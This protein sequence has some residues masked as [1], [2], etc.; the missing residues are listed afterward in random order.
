M[1][2]LAQRGFMVPTPSSKAAADALQ[3]L[4]DNQP[5][6]RY[7][8]TY[9]FEKQFDDAHEAIRL[10]YGDLFKNKESLILA[11]REL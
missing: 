5:V 11:I 8:P 1:L 6:Q 2:T 7:L 4:I 10:L 9:L 3:D